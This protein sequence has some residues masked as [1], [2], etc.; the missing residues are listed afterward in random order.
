M[1]D[2]MF[3]D[4][5]KVHAVVARSTFG[6]ENA[7][8]TTCSRHFWTLMRRLAWQ[9]QRIVHLVKSEQ[10]MRGGV[11]VSKTLAGMGHLEDL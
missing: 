8:S 11:A 9:A 7:Q 6:S 3:N 10:N 2:E 4:V 5:Q 1:E